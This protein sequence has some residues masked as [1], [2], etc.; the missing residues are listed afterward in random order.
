MISA[1]RSKRRALERDSRLGYDAPGMRWLT[2]LAMVLAVLLAATSLPADDGEGAVDLEGAR[3]LLVG[4]T[5]EYRASLERLLSIQ[6]VTATRTGDA[7]AKLHQLHERGFVSRRELE[8]GE[9][10]AADAHNQLSATRRR[11]T[12]TDTVL[13]ETLAAIELTRAATATVVTTST[14]IGARDGPD[15]TAAAVRDLDRFFV[16]RFARPLPVSAL[17]QTPVHDRLG[18]DHRHAL[19]IAVHPDSEEGRAVIAYLQRQH[20]P[21]LAFRG[22]VPG[23]ST[24]AHVHV[25]RTSARVTPVSVAPR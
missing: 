12:Q 24:G 2:G 6:E 9:R 5:R 8:E 13:A 22:M 3:S 14:V 4:A 16:S 11:L 17:G 7:A 25:G 19:D 23:A 10:S 1:D 20:I 21:F 15:L 18:I